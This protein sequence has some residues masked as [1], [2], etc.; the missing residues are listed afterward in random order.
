IRVWSDNL[1]RLFGL[2]PGEIAPNREFF[3]EH[4]HPDDRARLAR[5]MESSQRL[6]TPPPIEIRILHPRRG[7]RR[8]R[9]TM[10]AA[11]SRSGA[12]GGLERTDAP[13]SRT[14]GCGRSAQVSA[15][16]GAFGPGAALK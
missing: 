15:Q 7:V 16:L 1:Y 2:D 3:I 5:F 14:R 10:A 13:S 12:G 6:S 4:T 8:L 11:G 9:G